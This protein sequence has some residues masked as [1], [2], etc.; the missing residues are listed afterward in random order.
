M[1]SAIEDHFKA[2]QLANFPLQH[3]PKE[4]Q[5]IILHYVEFK[6]FPMEFFAVSILTAVGSAIGNS[7]VLKTFEGYINKANLYV[8]LVANP[9]LNKSAPL[10]TAF[11]Q[12]RRIQAALYEVFK[13][14]AKRMQ[15]D[16]AFLKGDSRDITKVLGENEENE[17]NEENIYIKPIM[18]DST[19]EALIGQLANNPHGITVVVD[20]IA[21]FLNSFD[22][23]N[24]GNDQ[25][26]YLSL[27]QGSQISRDTLLRGSIEVTNPFVAII[28]TI[29]PSEF[30]KSFKDKIA[31]G[32][33]DRF[34]IVFLSD[35][36]KPY[37]SSQGIN[38]IIER[39]YN[40]FIDNLFKL[41]WEDTTVLSYTPEAGAIVNEWVC[42]SIDVENASTTTD[43][44]R[45]IRAKMIIYV[46]RFALILQMMKYG[47]S[48][49]PNDKEAIYKESAVGA[50][51][52][53][54][55][56][57]AMA[58]K[59]RIKPISESIG[60]QVKQVYDMLPDDTAFTTAEFKNLCK[61]MDIVERTGMNYL[62]EYIGKLWDKPKYGTYTKII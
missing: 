33:L 25:Q 35:L 49:D 22:R 8:L 38:P 10:E 9:G 23:Y 13:K 60:G 57:L 20:E 34:I 16:I 19:I 58:E 52:L 54:D 61:M 3:F 31:N 15:T 47:F 39:E 45:S 24:K 11:A 32:F 40:D 55:Y 59:T 4:M 27:W 62:R 21:G 29:Q 18:Q 44:E 50:I 26:T 5:K 7:H 28:G 41:Y 37:P 12:L 51:L 48:L 1:S 14:N 43:I 53:A 42:R 6:G 2:K 17:K 56:F 30:N 46:H 36:K